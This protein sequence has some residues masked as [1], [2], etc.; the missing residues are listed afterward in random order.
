MTTYL[1]ITIIG[2]SLFGIV[3]SYPNGK[4]VD[5]SCGSMIPSHGASAQSVTAPFQITFC[6]AWYQAGSTVTVTISNTSMTYFK[7]FMVQARQ[8]P[9]TSTRYGTFMTTAHSNNACSSSAVV[10]NGDGNKARLSFQWTA[11]AAASGNLK[12]LATFVKSERVFW[13]QVASSQLTDMTGQNVTA[14][15]CTTT[16]DSS[17]S[18]RTQMSF[19]FVVLCICISNVLIITV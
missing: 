4:N 15:N 16:D 8:N 10:H 14:T 13:V 12:F 1:H 19:L 9:G 3:K 18:V 2:L 11:P 6:P 5:D 7:G 17:S